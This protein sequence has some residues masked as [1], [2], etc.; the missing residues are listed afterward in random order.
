LSFFRFGRLPAIVALVGAFAGH[1]LAQVT[2]TATPP[3]LTIPPGGSQNVSLARADNPSALAGVTISTTPP[4]G[5][6]T[7]VI[8]G[9]PGLLPLTLRVRVD[10]TFVGQG[11]INVTG[12][13]L[14]PLTIPINVG[15]TSSTIAASPNAVTFNLPTGQTTAIAQPLQVLS[16]TTTPNIGFGAT[17]GGALA[18]YITLSASGSFTPANIT[19]TINTPGAIPSNTT[20]TLNLTPSN[21]PT[22]TVPLTFIVGGAASNV[23]VSATSLPFIYAPGTTFVQPA[24]VTVNSTTSTPVN[25]TAALSG[26]IL[27]Y[28][29]LS[30]LSTT[31]PSQITV[32]LPNPQIIPAG[33]TGTLVITPTG[34][35]VVNIPITVNAGG[36]SLLSVT[37][38]SL[39]FN[40]VLGAQA[41]PQQTLTLFS[42]D[43]SQQSFQATA[44]STNNFLFVSPVFGTTPGT[45]SVGINMAAITQAGTYNGTITVTPISAVGSPL[46]IPV[47]V[48]VTGGITVTPDPA[49]V[50]L[51]AAPNGAPV[52]Q[53][54]Q[55]TSTSTAAY[56]VTAATSTGAGWLSAVANTGALSGGSVTI[57]ANPAGLALGTYTG[58][59]TVT[60][61]N[62]TVATIPVTLNVVQL[63]TLQITPPTG[64]AF[65]FQTGGSAPAAQAFQLASS[66]A[67]I[68]WNATAT[69]ASG[70]AWL[71]ITPPSGATPASL[72]VS[73][74]PTGLAPG[75]YNGS[76]TITSS[77]ATN[78]PQTVP[79]IL[80][81]TAVAQPQITTFVN[82]ASYTATTA[83]PGLIVT[84]FGSDLGPATGVSGQ[85]NAQGF[86]A[87]TVSETRVLFD[88]IAAPV[89][90]ASAGQVSA[91]VPFE[92]FGRFTTRL[93]VEYRGQ[94]SRELELRVADTAPGIFTAA[95]SGSGPAAA[96]NQNGSLNSATNPE[97]RGNV[98]VIYATGQ[99]ITS[100]PSTTGRVSSDLL[101]PVAP[102]SVRIGGV[103]A[104]ILYAGSAPG[105]V[106]GGV[107]IN[108]RIP[109]SLPAGSAPVQVQIGTATSQP[110]VTIAVR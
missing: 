17:L 47:T 1:A 32:S 93:Q 65:S 56:T 69:T 7:E 80:T 3:N 50:T 41:P 75:T 97:A 109:A 38:T 55:L 102:V 101:R 89:I 29:Q 91:I 79:I 31:T 14:Q 105:L 77:N 71:Q 20:G 76:V 62:T 67:V 103:E 13:G 74:N 60:A 57:T 98:V 87:T 95:S 81:V 45:L 59:V 54:V 108:A 6:T 2:I 107:Q 88:G 49:A 39:A 110:G 9:V 106:A 19:L 24:I 90:Y 8:A 96:L 33:T 48:V 43:L 100:P 18:P 73:V 42:T 25:F 58:T 46:S 28:A 52:Q 82:A 40:A 30:L 78:S 84:I 22:I 99:G 63:A 104:E 5:I 66:G 36:S 83:V 44:T 53:T 61:Q 86:L 85:V 68:N 26:A 37:P 11:F 72:S 16:T 94:R 34:G 64:L 92:I 35:A 23:T 10:A 12:Q 51:T 4:T 21:G 15:G 27:S 70:G